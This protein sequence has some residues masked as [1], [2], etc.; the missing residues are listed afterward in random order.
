[1]RKVKPQYG[2]TRIVSRFLIFPVTIGNE[3]RWLER[4]R[5]KQEYKQGGYA[6]D[7]DYWSDEEF[8]IDDS[9]L[10]PDNQLEGE[11]YSPYIKTLKTS[12]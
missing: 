7:G 5:I 3:T 9:D 11:S 1:M 4:A 2:S 6:E 10:V 8:I 12:K